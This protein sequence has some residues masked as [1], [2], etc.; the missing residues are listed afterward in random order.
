MALPEFSHDHE[1]KANDALSGLG[2]PG[3]T[4]AVLLDALL[5]GESDYRTTTRDN[6]GIQRGVTRWGTPIRHLRETLRPSG[7]KRAEPNSLPLVISPDRSMAIT[8]ATG[9]EDTGNPRASFAATKWDK[10]KMI[11]DWIDPPPEQLALIGSRYGKDF[12]ELPALWMLLVRRAPGV[13]IA[14]FSQPTSVT[15]SKHIRFGG[16]RIFIRPLPIDQTVP[17]DD[18]D[19]DEDPFADIPVQRL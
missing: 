2:Q 1:E 12:M 15:K 6:P 11:C 10:G 9:N 14:E 3:L 5:A 19:E 18:D 8:V 4:Q 16:N 7:W 13:V 17:V